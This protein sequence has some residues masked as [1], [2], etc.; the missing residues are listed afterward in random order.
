MEF[1]INKKIIILA[2]TGALFAAFI[3]SLP[4]FLIKRELNSKG[5]NYHPVTVYVD[6]DE[7]A[8]YGPLVKEGIEKLKLA[9][10]ALYEHRDTALL[11]P[12]TS[13]VFLGFLGRIFGGI[14]PLRTAINFIFPPIIFLLF[15]A[16]MYILTGD[17]LLTLFFSLIFIVTLG[18]AYLPPFSKFQQLID[19]AVYFKP[20]ISTAVNYQRLAFD[21]IFSPAWT[22]IPY[23]SFWFLLVFSLLKKRSSLF[24]LTG[25]VYGLLFYTYIY[26]WMTAS[27]TLGI[28]LLIMILSKNL[29]L[30]KQIGISIATGLLASIFY[31]IN[32][33]QVSH[34]P[35]YE[36]IRIRL[37][38]EVGRVFRWSYLPHYIFWLFLAV[39]LWIKRSKDPLSYL[40]VAIFISGVVVLNVQLIIGYIS[41]PMHFLYYSL[42]LSLF[43]AY[44]ICVMKILNYRPNWK[45]YAKILVGMGTLLILTRAVQFQISYAQGNAWRYV[46]PKEKEDSFEWLRNNTKEDAIV[47]T[48]DFI[49]N[50][51]LMIL[52]SVKVFY[53]PSGYVTSAS[54]KEI[55]ERYIISAKLFGF[56]D[57]YI[58]KIFSREFYADI[59]GNTRWSQDYIFEH[60]MGDALMSRQPDPP[61]GFP[62]YRDFTDL[63]K[64]AESVLKEWNSNKDSLLKKYSFEYVY[65]GPEERAYGFSEKNFPFCLQKVYQN[66]EVNIYRICPI[67]N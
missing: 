49:T 17:S 47:L 12:P 44:A 35:Q 39:W 67:K 32:Y 66:K 7:G 6:Y 14:E 23:A 8:I 42:G 10:P 20:Y 37:G 50:T 63:E 18:I 5:V 58:K 16:V 41:W 48:P 13:Q 36:D 25:L 24:I 15:F 38:P 26:D 2:A 55:I 4:H 56:T 31:W 28:L 11:W 64:I 59:K 46:I 54:N 3:Y 52:T 53:P 30:A 1:H 57:E 60:I 21:R 29:S 34:F 43:I 51:N 22:F 27:A 40:A 62:G 9:D 45:F 61:V 33:W 19:F 65:V